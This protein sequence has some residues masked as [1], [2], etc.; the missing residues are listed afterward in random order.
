[1][2]LVT[3]QVGRDFAVVGGDTSMYGTMNGEV[4]NDVCEGKEELQDIVFR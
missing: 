1:M 4:M 3:R 2:P